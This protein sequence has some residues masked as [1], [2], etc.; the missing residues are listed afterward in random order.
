MEIPSGDIGSGERRP[1]PRGKSAL[2]F[3]AVVLALYALLGSLAQSHH[4]A[5]GLAWTEVF[6]FLL[7]SVA[8]AAG[9][10]LD[11]RSFLLLRVRPSA[12]QLALGAGIGAAL[13]LAA[14]GVMTLTTMALPQ[15]WVETFDLTHLFL[16]SGP[17]RAGMALMASVVA[18][19][20]EEIAFRG[21]ALSALRTW[22]RPWPSIAA[23]AVLFAVMHLD[24]VRFPAV[25]LLGIAFGWLAWR[26]GSIWPS[27]A[28]H[29]V[30]NGLGTA[31]AATGS[32][33]PAADADVLGALGILAVGLAALAPLA[34][35]YWRATPEPPRPEEST[36][37]LDPG[38]PSI[39]FRWPRVPTA[40]LALGLA[41]LAILA[42][43]A[44]F[45][46]TLPRP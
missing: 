41:G 30:N 31:I 36:V 40:F 43:L 23:C 5:L 45:P 28:A 22:A 32:A 9:S 29:A 3:F 15:R 33:E 24:P 38:D 27:V 14:S 12:V 6:V 2:G 46:G 7:P 26:S 19:V 34:L 20:A 13:F 21:Y 4:P 42:A 8:A 44:A 37:L 1:G 11:P 39:R 18:P 35:L 10:N 16:G 17:E 25:L